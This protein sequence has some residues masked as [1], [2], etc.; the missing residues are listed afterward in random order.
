MDTPHDMQ[1]PG[2]GAGWRAA[3][4]LLAAALALPAGAQ[5]VPRAGGE[6]PV[7]PISPPAVPPPVVV[8]P[9]VAAPGVSPGGASFELRRVRFAGATVFSDSELQAIAAPDIGRRVTLADLEALA[10]RVTAYYRSWGY[11]LAQAIVPVQEVAGG[12][13]EVSVLE[14]RLGRVIVELDPQTPIGEARVREFVDRLPVGRPLREDTLTRVLLLL[15]D[16]PGVRAE[17]A[18]GA[19]EAPGS[20][21]L[22]IT[23]APSRR[24]DLN[25]D[26]DNYGLQSTSLYRVG[27]SGRWN[28]PFGVGDNLDLRLQAGVDGR[29]AFGRIGY[30]RPVGGDGVRAGVALSTLDYA[31]VSSFTGLDADG[32]ATVLELATTYALLRSRERNLF[33][34]VLLQRM[35]L[36]ESYSTVGLDFDKTITGF[37]MSLN[38]EG[39]DRV[40]GGGYTGGGLNFYF[41]N[42][43]LDSATAAEDARNTAG[44][45]N[46]VAYNLSRLQSLRSD[47]QVFVGVT[48]QLTDRNLDPVQKIALGGPQAVRAYAPAAVIADEG[49]VIHA[50]LRYSPRAELS[51]QGFYDW[52]WGRLNKDPVP[53]F[54]A[55]NVVRLWGYGAGLFWGGSEGLTVR[56]SVA[57]PNR[58][59]PGSDQQVPQVYVQIA[60]SM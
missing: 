53:A 48:G 56:A 37:G 30:E 43:S 27:V 57:W 12:V 6:M 55:D 1:A 35:W 40:L 47:A 9:P 28:S 33:S 20:T 51:L 14:G 5:T 21:D 54:D 41:G 19:G 32:R 52:G 7:A 60:Y 25:F 38:Y 42:L 39:S 49:A 24:W 34:K 36:T 31:L 3:G 46:V 59:L 13:V 17:A 29:L 15:S 2:I 18:L 23:V 50:E 58:R 11:L 26:A 44:H 8:P 16:L 4:A 10:Q 45:F 22:T